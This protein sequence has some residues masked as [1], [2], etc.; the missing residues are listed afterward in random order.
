VSEPTLSEERDLFTRLET[1]L[2]VAIQEER[3]VTDSPFFGLL[4]VSD[5]GRILTPRKVRKAG[6]VFTALDAVHG[7]NGS[8]LSLH[9]E[10]CAKDFI[11]YERAEAGK[12]LPCPGSHPA[13]KRMAEIWRGLHPR[14]TPG[15]DFGDVGHV[16]ITRGGRR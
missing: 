6:M 15:Y 11:F 13:Y 3:T 16:S 5:E 2:M 10:G 1:R 4:F 9:H 8:F 14:A 12:W 7:R